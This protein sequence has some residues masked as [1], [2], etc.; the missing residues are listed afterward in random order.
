VTGLVGAVDIGASKTLVAVVGLPISDWHMRRRVIRF[1]TPR[2]PTECVERVARAVVELAGNGMGELLAVGC[3]TPGPLDRQRGVVIHSPN[4]G[5]RDVPIGPWLTERLGVPA[6]IDDDART[7]AIGEAVLGAG[8]GADPVAYLTISSGIGSGSVLGGRLHHGAHGVA[9][10]VGHLVLEPGGPRCSC[11]N[12]GCVEAYASGSGLGRRARLTWRGATMPDGRL[13]PRSAADVFR[14]ALVGDAD[15]R[16]LVDEAAEALALALAS[17][18]ATLD[19][20]LIV[21]GGSL[22]LAQGRFVRRAATIARRRCMREAAEHLRVLP[23]ALGA[24][25][26]LAGSAVLAEALIARE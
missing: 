23:A 25:S 6:V 16:R 5:W 7:G 1:D 20:E 17:I 12:R 13:A 19:P 9:G 4:Q 15:A 2:D 14:A 26:V 24:E 18:A 10:E 11:G 8:V 22:G 21:V 3:G